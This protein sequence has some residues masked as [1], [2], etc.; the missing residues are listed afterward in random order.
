[1]GWIGGDNLPRCEQTNKP[2]RHTLS[3]LGLHCGVGAAPF[4]APTAV[5]PR[6][7]ETK[8]LSTIYAE[9]KTHS[10]KKGFDNWCVWMHILALFTAQSYIGT[11]TRTEI[12]A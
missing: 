8:Q 10:P 1:M 12:D 7:Q 6:N 5:L 4:S 11:S 3:I 9:V 2:D